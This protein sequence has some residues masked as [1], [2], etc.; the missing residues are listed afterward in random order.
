MFVVKGGG[1]K[2]Y[3]STTFTQGHRE[4]RGEVVYISLCLLMAIVQR[5]VFQS[6]RLKQIIEAHFKFNILFERSSWLEIHLSLMG[7]AQDYLVVEI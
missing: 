5:K 1:K 4:E 6:R 3:M 2:G 7:C